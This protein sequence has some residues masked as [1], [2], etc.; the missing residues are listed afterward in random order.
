[1]RVLVRK[2]IILKGD[3]VYAYYGG[4]GHL[5]TS[6]PP[7]AL[8]PDPNTPDVPIY[9]HYGAYRPH[10]SGHAGMGELIPGKFGVGKHGEMV[11][12]DENGEAHHHGI[13]GVIHA[14]GESLEKNGILGQNHPV[15]GVLDPKLL[16][17]KAIDMTNSEH[18]DKTGAQ[19]I[20][21][22]DSMKHRKIR[23][24][25]YGGRRPTVRAHNTPKGDYITAYTNRPN[26]KERIGAMIESYAVPYNHNLSRILLETLGLDDLAGAEFLDN[27]HIDIA[28]LHPRGRRIRGRG[29]DAIQQ[30]PDGFYLPDSHIQNAPKDV[31]HNAAHTGIRSW[32]VQHHTPDF[33][34]LTSKSKGNPSAM[35]SAEHHITEALKLIDPDK[36]PD[37]E[38]PI[39]ATPDSTAVP[40]Y[41]MMNLRTVLRSPTAR[42][43][44]IQELSKTPAF[45][46]LFGRINSGT[47]ARPGIGKRAF[48]HLINAFGGE[49]SYN[50]LKDHAVPGAKLATLP[51]NLKKLGTHANA[52]KFYAKAMM[53][54]PHDEHDSALRAYVPRDAEGNVDVAAIEGMGLTMQS[55]DT[56]PQRRQATQ[57]I[58]DMVA[59]AFG[60]QVRRPLPENIP[61]TALASR[62]ILGYPE[63]LIESLPEHIPFFDDT[64]LAPVQRQTTTRAEP[65]TVRPAA[66]R[67]PP[68]T[69][70]PPVAAQPQ[71]R[72]T[73]EPQSIASPPRG[74]PMFRPQSPQL[75]AARQQVAQADPMR[76]REIMEAAGV[77]VPQGQGQQLSPR[78]MQFQQTMGDPRQQ[79]LTQYMKSISQDLSPMDRVMKAM[80]DMQMDDARSDAQVMKHALPRQINVADLHGINHL[81]KSVNLTPVDVRTIA[82]STGDW[83]RIAKRLNVSSNIVKV[84]KVSVGGI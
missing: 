39:N 21:D 18:A 71:P 60:H 35:K 27:P 37:V 56:I 14:I 34:H 84:V 11:Y 44:M 8:H 9:A 67:P 61:T 81:A 40:R 77:R 29:G 63:Q 74:A 13:D 72:P 75:V 53:S 7:E 58:A 76:L 6:P 20:P 12:I 48:E 26:R 70:A 51:A 49:D 62:M 65:S 15:L 22:V 4:Q 33:M 19:D 25:G 50:T 1:M 2:S 82:H 64:G 10:K 47:A 24:A 83:E 17:Q 30:R 32:E 31:I 38:V 66:E 54:G 52:A 80:E 42:A 69:V 28:D 73:I 23:I 41:T 5:L 45:V 79:L 57:A 55:A 59:T 68:A 78:E 3:G 43:N 46:K 36:I 16:V